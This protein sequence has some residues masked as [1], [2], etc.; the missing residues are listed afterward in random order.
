MISNI[1]LTAA[2]VSSM[3]MGITSGYENVRTAA[4][5]MVGVYHAAAQ[6]DYSNPETTDA[7]V[8]SA[9]NLQGLSKFVAEHETIAVQ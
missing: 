4:Y 9:Q 5:N 8:A 2:T 7:L 3:V 6:V 1:I